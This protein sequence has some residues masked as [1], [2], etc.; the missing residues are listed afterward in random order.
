M[1]PLRALTAGVLLW[2]LSFAA[3]SAQTVPLHYLSTTTNNSTLV[4]AGPTYLNALVVVNT[5]AALYYLK[6]YNKVTA[7]TCGTDTPVWTVPIPYG[8]SGAGGGVAIPNGSL[9]FSAGLGFCITAGIADN[10]NTSAVAGIAV[11]FG[12]SGAASSP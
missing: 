6:L 11:D 2:L 1:K 5:T 10:D 8:A 12:I 7:P 4:R 9:Q 3:V